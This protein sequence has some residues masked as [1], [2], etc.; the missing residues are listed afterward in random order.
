MTRLSSKV[1][2]TWIRQGQLANAH[3]GTR[4][5]VES[6]SYC[7]SEKKI[8]ASRKL[9]LH[10]MFS[11]RG[12]QK[13]MK[14]IIHPSKAFPVSQQFHDECGRREYCHSWNKRGSRDEVIQTTKAKTKACVHY[15][16]PNICM[17]TILKKRW[18]K[19][20]QSV[21]ITFIECR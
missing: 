19:Q 5:W 16:S 10:F 6:G 13:E 7:D 21:S 11:Q 2:S 12:S 4:L 17:I 9:S 14:G 8:E 18:I 3:C 20:E 1:T 15:F